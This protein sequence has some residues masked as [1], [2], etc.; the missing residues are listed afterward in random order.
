MQPQRSAPQPDTPSRDGV[1][2]ADESLFPSVAA[3]RVVDGYGVKITVYRARLRVEDGIGRQRRSQTYSRA[4]C[5]FRRLLTLGHTGYISL[6]AVR[7]CWDLDID[8]IQIDADRNLL[9]DQCQARGENQSA[10]TN[11]GPGAIHDGGCRGRAAR[12]R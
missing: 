11:P 3:V 9:L 10:A 1:G 2:E 6:E 4:T 12:I 5:P 7:W 8:I